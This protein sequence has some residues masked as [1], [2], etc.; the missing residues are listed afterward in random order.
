MAKSV[1]MAKKVPYSLEA[2]QAVLGCILI[3][4]NSALNIC[5]VLKEDAFY[6]VAHKNIYHAM[7][8]LY[9]QNAPIDFVTVTTE[10]DKN[11]QIDQIGGYEYITN[12]T[13]IVPTSANYE[14]YMNLVKR[15][16]TLRQLID[17]GEKIIQTA[18]ESDDG[19]NAL[20]LAEKEIFDIGEKEAVSHLEQINGPMTDIMQKFETIAKDR[21]SLRGLPTGFAGL[22]K[23]LN[24]LQKGDLILLAARPGVGKTTLAMNMVVNTALNAKASVAVFSLE[25]P[26]VQLAERAVCSHANVSMEKAEKGDL[27]ADDWTCLWSAVKD[28]SDSK[29]YVD[30][31]SLNTVNDIFRKCQKIKREKGLDL[32]MIDYLQLMSAP[33]DGKKRDNRQQEISEMTRMLKIMAKELQVPVLLLSQLSRAVENKARADHR[34]VLSDLRESGAIEQDA[35]IVMFIYN[36]DQYADPNMPKQ[37]I[38]ELIIEKHRNGPRGLVKLKFIGECTTFKSMD[39]DLNTESLEKTAPIKKPSDN[40]QILKMEDTNIDDIFD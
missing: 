38:V 40:K 28:F 30:D 21:D 7:M 33:Q 9:S 20:K 15:D 14:H 3:S 35:D 29:I 16:Y 10:L 25:M 8:K 11:G 6:S 23:L 12:L 34:P 32:V 24:G 26:K 27:T 18:Y 1:V 22:D 17:V 5:S 19:E 36:P 2:E 4:E 37:N 31:S 13:N 39:L